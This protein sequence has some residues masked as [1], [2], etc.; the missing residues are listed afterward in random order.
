M[1]KPIGLRIKVV[2]AIGEG[3]TIAE[4]TQN[5]GVSVWTIRR[6]LRRYQEGG[7][8]LLIK[9]RPYILPWNIKANEIAEKVYLLKERYPKITLSQARKRLSEK[10]IQ[11]SIWYIRKIWRRYGLTGYD[12][13]KQVA[14]IIPKMSVP[15]DIKREIDNAARILEQ[16]GDVRE[17]AK[18]LNRLPYCGWVEILDKIPFGYLGLRRRVEKIPYLYGKEPLHEFYQK[19][20]SLRLSLEKKKLLYSSLRVGIAEANILHWLGRPMQTLSLMRLL[21]KRMPKQGDPILSYLVTLFKGMA[22]ARLLKLGDAVQCAIVCKR[23]IK[24]L[25]APDFCVGLGNLYSNIGLYPQAKNWYKKASHDASGAIRDQCL[26]AL[27]G[28]YAL[29]GEYQEVTKTI[30]ELKQKVSPAYTIIP[31]IRAQTLLGKGMLMEAAQSANT[32]IKVAKKDEIVQYLHA[33]TIVLSCVYY[34]LC[35]RVRAK[36]L[37]QSVIPILKKNRMMQDYYIRRLYLSK[38]IISLPERY[39]D[40]PFI[41]LM[42]TIKRANQTLRVKDYSYAL[43]FAIRKGLIGYFHRLCIFNSEIVLKLIEKGR[44]TGLPRAMLN[45]P[46]FR[47]EIPVYSVKFLGNLIVYK[48]QKYQKM[49]L[50]PKDTAFLV[51]LATAKSNHIALDRIYKNFWPD[52]KNPARNLAHLLVRIRKALYLPSH[53]LYVRNNRLS[54]DCHFITDY[55]EYLE[56]LAQAK[57]FLRAGEWAF[58]EAE[59]LHAFSLFRDAPFKK[60]YDNWSEDMRRV[61]LNQLENAALDFAKFCSSHRNGKDARRVLRKVSEIMPCSDEVKRSLD[62]L[63]VD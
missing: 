45:L 44:P 2:E 8:E 12:K 36:A 40:E 16:N 26:L 4:V 25:P 29:N 49:K 48:N 54:Y 15:Q 3:Q 9:P 55:G 41:K 13:K 62:S 30:R 23:F 60:M 7:V 63:V 33:A 35:D 1:T 42:L 61:I 43:R 46:V 34:A 38:D 37:I 20:H 10:G 17:A 50:T 47:K 19:V 28:C 21:E 6:W 58:A 24:I 18:I 11:L 27:A 51:H 5:F 14:E 32:A 52:S 22:L 56:H 39:K 59:Y 31:L 53:F 57:A